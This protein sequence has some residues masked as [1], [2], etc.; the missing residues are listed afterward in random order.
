MHDLAGKVAVVTGGASGIGLALA[1]R[2]A[3]EGM[4]LVLADVEEPALEQARKGLAEGGAEVLAVP[5]DVADH[6]SVVALR[7]AALERFGAVHLV[8]NNAGVV[9]G[10]I[11]RSPMSMWE[12]VVGV[13]LF[14]VVN[15]CN[16]FLPILVGQD[17]GHIVNTASMAGLRGVG[18]LGIYCTTKFAVVGLSESLADELAASGSRVGVSV[19]CPG[20]VHTRIAE[21]ARNMPEWVRATSPE[22]GDGAGPISGLVASGMPPAEVADAVTQ[23]VLEGRLY[24]L[25]HPE[26]AR[27]AWEH[28]GRLLFGGS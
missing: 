7:D 21:S 25:T 9:G 17:E 19:V 2:F 22:A 5:T 24:V 15:G 23:A 26:M 13:N 20:F 14:G 12:W 16:V 27:D 18:V 8:C 1:Q 6:A 28:R 10:S 11:V 4:R 3:D